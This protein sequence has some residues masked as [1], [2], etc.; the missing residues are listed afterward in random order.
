M[1]LIKVVGSG[2]TM[3]LGKTMG[4]GK[5]MVLD[6]TMV[7]GKTM[8]FGKTMGSGKTAVAEEVEEGINAAAVT[9][10]RYNGRSSVYGI[11][12]LSLRIS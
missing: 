6:K 8:R 12:N 11:K 2:K 5:T 1:V 4:F 3:V 10:C 9:E 7:S